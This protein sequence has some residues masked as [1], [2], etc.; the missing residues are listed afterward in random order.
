MSE[1]AIENQILRRV[2]EL[3]TMRKEYV[4]VDEYSKLVQ[5]LSYRMSD[6]E[7]SLQRNREELAYTGEYGPD[8][9]QR[10]ALKASIEDLMSDSTLAKSQL[11]SLDQSILG[12]SSLKN[13]SIL[14]EISSYYGDMNYLMF[15]SLP[16]QKLIKDNM[17][18]ERYKQMQK[19]Q[20][21][22]PSL[23]RKQIAIIQEHQ[24]KYMY[25]STLIGLLWLISLIVFL[26]KGR[27]IH[28]QL[29]RTTSSKK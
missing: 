12:Y 21:T 7:N 29:E 15:K 19:I 6:I 26:L 2:P 9:L 3:D 24:R 1:F 11:D 17:K 16:L 27:N 10:V 8:N 13:D 28:R 18:P 22:F 4:N 5:D 25:A 23:D 20:E 14:G